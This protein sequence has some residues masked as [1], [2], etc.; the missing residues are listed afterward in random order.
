MAIHESHPRSFADLLDG[1]AWMRLPEEVRR[2]FSRPFHPGMTTCYRGRI[3]GTYLSCAGR[4][5]AH[6]ARLIGAPLPLNDEAGLA[7]V[8]VTDHPGTGGQVWTRL[9]HSRDGMPQVI[10]SV[11]R[12]AGLTGLEEDLGAGFAIALE[13][14][15]EHGAL[16]FTGRHYSWRM[17]GIR[18]PLPSWLT[19]GTL[20][21]RNWQGPGSRFYFSLA[22]EHPRLGLLIHQ[23]LRFDDNATSIACADAGSKT[24]WGGVATPTPTLTPTLTPTP[25]PTLTP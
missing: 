9:Y 18:L 24:A 15:V 22:L 1:D 19:P 5:V 14:S 25:T 12:L 21:V 2:R 11:K 8:V 20:T 6:L 16:V 10:Q 7:T 3:V 17:A 13:L 23:Q 4:V